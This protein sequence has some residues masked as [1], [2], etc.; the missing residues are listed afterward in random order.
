MFIQ[1]TGKQVA[2]CTYTFAGTFYR[3]EPFERIFYVI[4]I[5]INFFFK[6]RKTIFWVFVTRICMGI[7][8]TH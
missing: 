6:P 3:A 7:Q 5:C 2:T 1:L 4:S 8:V